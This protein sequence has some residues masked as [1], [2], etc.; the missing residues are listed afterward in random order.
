MHFFNRLLLFFKF[1]QIWLQRRGRRETI[2]T[3]LSVSSIMSVAKPGD[4]LISFEDQR[5][6]S[7]FIKGDF[8]HAAIITED[9]Q[10]VESV[11]DLFYN[12]KN[13]GGVRKVPLM[14]WL[15]KKD[16]VALI[17]PNL[18]SPECNLKAAR[19]SLKYIGKAYD[20]SFSMNG[21][22]IYCSELPYLCYTT[23][24]ITFMDVILRKEILPIDYL[25][26]CDI[27]PYRFMVLFN[28]RKL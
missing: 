20:Y 10:V 4:I 16:H 6:T 13:L 23:E 24:D 9:M 1:F 15:Y 2:I 14:G 11:G 22:T 5:W 17:R 26:M 7:F 12:G 27:Q 18:S 8:D 21:E 28:T 3:D 25:T 19:N